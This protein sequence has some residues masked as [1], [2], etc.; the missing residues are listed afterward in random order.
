MDKPIEIPFISDLYR[1]INDGQ[2]LTLL[3]LGSLLV[4]L[5]TSLVKAIQTSFGRDTRSDAAGITATV[6]GVAAGVAQTSWAF[7]GTF[8]QG[9]NITIANDE[10]WF[11]AY[12]AKINLSVLGA[13][14]FVTRLIVLGSDISSL[15]QDTI[16]TVSSVV[17]WAFPTVALCVDIFAAGVATVAYDTT[18]FGSIAKWVGRVDLILGAVLGLGGFT[19]MIFY[20]GTGIFS[21]KN[22]LASLISNMLLQL[23]LGVRG[24]VVF[25]RLLP[26]PYNVAAEI[27]TITTLFVLNLSAGVLKIAG[28]FS[29]DLGTA[30]AA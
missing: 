3:D 7:F 25:A 23:A 8:L 2:A 26:G 13:V 11:K 17:V 12:V 6:W 28:T 5:P 21:W 30:A 22:D 18:V 27:A 4:A 9:A 15:F 24:L 29:P 10:S 1:L 16:R 19:F 14:G 20:Y